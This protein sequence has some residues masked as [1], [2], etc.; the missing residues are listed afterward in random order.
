METNRQ[1]AENAKGRE[2][3][4]EIDR[5]AYTVIGAAIEVHRV[6]GPG[7]LEEV[8]GKALAIELSR[9]GIAY[10]CEKCVTVNYKGYEVGK[11]RLDFFIAN[12]LI[13][14]LKAVQNLAPIHEAQVLSY[15]KITNYPLALLINFNVPILKEGIKRIIL[16][17]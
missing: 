16:S 3:S 2:P 15:L 13:V 17:S 6:L 1:D 9:R 11:G 4:K 10:E 12:T 14:E 8:Y 7:F 5:L